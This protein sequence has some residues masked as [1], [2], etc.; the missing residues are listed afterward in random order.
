MKANKSIVNVLKEGKKRLILDLCYVNKHIYKERIKFEDL[1]LTEQFL[2]P[3]EYTYTW[4]NIFINHIKS[5]LAFHGKLGVGG[6]ACYFLKTRNLYNVIENQWLWDSRM[7][8]TNYEKAIKEL[9]FSK[10]NIKIFNKKPLRVYN[11]AKT[12]I[13]L[14]A[15]SC[16]IWAIFENEPR[17]H[18]CHKI[19]ITK[20]HLES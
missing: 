2:N 6:G 15:S 17:T 19:L 5:F 3:C 8:L 11:L 20:E 16:A 14:D 12:F 13:F 7:N 4:L 9:I 10:S 18:T 1:K